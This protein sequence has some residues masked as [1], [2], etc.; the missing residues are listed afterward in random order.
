MSGLLARATTSAATATGAA[1]VGDITDVLQRYFDGLHHG[2][3]PTLA[4]VFHPL[5]TYSCATDG[6]LVHLTMDEYFPIVAA[7]EAPA[8]RGESRRDEIVA[9][10]LVGPVTALARV[11]CS[12]GPK[13]F[14]DLLSLVLVDDRWQI[15]AKVFHYDVDTAG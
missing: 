6:S 1:A 12:I 4:G 14:S 2:D 13:R 15:V 11:R 9:I 10:E 5:A 3:V 7:R 8:A